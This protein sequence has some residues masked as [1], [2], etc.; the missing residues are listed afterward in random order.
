METFINKII[1]KR[2]RCVEKIGS[3]GMG[4]VY[5]AEDTVLNR[6]VAVKVLRPTFKDEKNQSRF[7]REAKILSQLNHP[8]IVTIHDFGMWK[9]NMYIVLEYL[10]GNNLQQILKKSGPFP[11]TW[12]INA[13]PQMMDA[14][15]A[16]HHEGIIHRDLKPS[17]IFCLKQFDHT[18]YI[19]I[20]DFGTAVS[21]GQDILDKITPTGEVIGSPRYM[22]PEQIMGREISPCSDI[23]ALGITMYEILS[24]K[25]PFG[26]DNMMSIFLSHL[27][28]PPRPIKSWKD[29]N[30]PQI[31]NLREIV[32]TC[33]NKNPEDR[34]AS[35]H[36]LRKALTEGPKRKFRLPENLVGERQMRF[37]QYYLG[38]IEDTHIETRISR[39]SPAHSTPLLV[40]EAENSPIENT[41][42]PLLKIT[43]HS[44]QSPMSLD[45]DEIKKIKLP[46]AIV[47]NKGKEE[48]LQLIREIQRIKEWETI[49][50]FICGPE[51]DLDYISRAIDAGAG[52]YLSYPFDPKEIINKIERANVK[53]H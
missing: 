31:H 23:Y 2:Y 28:Q 24:G 45:W 26:G 15:E 11:V 13:L 44:V 22:S 29:V 6:D 49:P 10:D 9:K 38:P 39:I 16:A 43:N 48:N 40:I 41:I 27:Y 30:D 20:L 21:L 37:K 19:K 7:F 47:L 14:L 4:V 42:T 8:H 17:N 50:V 32:N 5:L 51:G 25:P 3:G 12:L 1:A 35:I 53:K 36:E 34:Y 33:L 52:D 18:D 46:G